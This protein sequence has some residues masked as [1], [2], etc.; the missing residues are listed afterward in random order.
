MD[1][2]AFLFILLNNYAGYR[3]KEQ[4]LSIPQLVGAVWETCTALKKTP[5]TNIT[6]IGRAI[7]QTAVSMK[8]VLREMKELKPASSDL[9]DGAADEVPT[10]SENGSPDSDNSS[11]GD[12][13]NDLSQEEMEV[14]QIAIGVVSDLLIVVK[15]LI[16]SITYLLKKKDSDGSSDSVNSLEKLLKLCQGIGVQVDELGACLYPPQEFTS[17][18]AASEKM[19]S[20]VDEMQVELDKLN[21]SSEAFLKACTALNASLRQ[22]G[23]EPLSSTSADLLRKVENLDL[24]R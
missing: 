7:T 19:S 8:D 3:S 24:N 18:K 13:G 23:S 20:M 21:G 11:E 5:T 15:E 1:F 9:T 16:R 17:I 2:L 4:K 12:L 22:L 14:A 6:A 10:K